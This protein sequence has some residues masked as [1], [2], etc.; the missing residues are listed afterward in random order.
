MTK[1]SRTNL[2]LRQGFAMRWYITQVGPEPMIFL[3]QSLSH[4][5][6]SCELP[7]HLIHL[8]VRWD[9]K[10]WNSLPKT[11]GSSRNEEN[12]HVS[13]RIVP[14]ILVSVELSE[15]S[16]IN[17]SLFPRVSMGMEVL[18]QFMEYT[19]TVYFSLTLLMLLEPRVTSG[20]C[21]QCL[22]LLSLH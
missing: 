15:R 11:T 18:F 1:R 9:S 17:P 8:W 4:R 10:I 22:D 5:D 19:K 2:V 16:V 21:Q 13:T 20:C 14:F 7:S 6:Y 3:P 12:D